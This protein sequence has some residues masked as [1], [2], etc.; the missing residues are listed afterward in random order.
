MGI[1]R[2]QET[3]EEAARRQRREEDQA[4]RERQREEDDRQ[5]ELF[6]EAEKARVLGQ[7]RGLNW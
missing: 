3:R 7:L 5:R 2:P 6:S 1:E 4:N